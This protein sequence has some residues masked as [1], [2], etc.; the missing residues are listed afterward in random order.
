MD[1]KYQK[2]KIYKITDLGH[3]EMYIGSTVQPLSKR[4]SHHKDTYLTHP[5]SSAY[6]FETYGKDNCK[7]ILIE[8]YPCENREQLRAREGYYIETLNCVNKF[9]PGG[10]KS[11]WDKR[12]YNKN[13]ETI[14]EKSKA[15]YQEHKTEIKEKCKQYR[16]NNRER[17]REVDKAYRINK[18]EELNAKKL[19]PILCEC[20]CYSVRSSIARHMKSKKH[21]KLMESKTASIL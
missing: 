6:M 5:C 7:V 17:K 2:S 18:W 20:G 11:D 10:N 15:H 12:Y 19:E 13:K 1:N 14:S 21:L 9:I 8:E 4:F 3:N 16:E